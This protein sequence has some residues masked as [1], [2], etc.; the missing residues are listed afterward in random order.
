MLDRDLIDKNIC[1]V[2]NSLESRIATDLED[3]FLI[4]QVLDADLLNKLQ[5]YLTEIP[6]TQWGCVPGQEHRPR[7]SISWDFDTVIEELHETFNLVT[8]DINRMFPEPY[9]YFWGISIWRDGPGYDIEWH[10][11]NPDIDIAMQVYLYGQPGL[12]TV[13]RQHDREILAPSQ[14]NAGYLIRQDPIYK[15]PHRSQGTVPMDTVRY[16][17]YMVWS[18][19]PKQT[20]NSARHP[21]DGV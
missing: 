17:L 21:G 4:S 6:Q 7:R 11:D 5:K 16:S 9:K 12:G 10:R 1:S 2:K 13:F 3:L 19:F 20:T 18:R 15:I 14:H 8:P